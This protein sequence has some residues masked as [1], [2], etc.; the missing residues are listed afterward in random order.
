MAEATDK[1]KEIHALIMAKDDLAFA[2]FCN[3]YYEPVYEKIKNYNKVIFSESETLI[4]DVV[5]DSFLNYFKNP[6]RFNPKKQTLERFLIMDAEGDLKNEWEKLQRKNKKLTKSVELEAENGNSIQDSEFNP[7]EAIIHKE[8]IELLEKKLKETFSNGKDVQMAHLML[9]GERK[10]IEFA[11]VLEIEHLNEE[12]Q[13]VEIKRQ[14]DR[15]DKI[16]RR[17]LRADE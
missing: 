17:K 16:I 1:E 2:K 15:I 12:G 4:I 3:D 13:R 9:S 7:I 6:E 5:T 10:S 8:D 11:K 14:K